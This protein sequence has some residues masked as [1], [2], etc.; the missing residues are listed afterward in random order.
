MPFARFSLL[1]N[2]VFLCVK[3]YV[4]ACVLPLSCTRKVVVDNKKFRF[5]G[6]NFSVGDHVCLSAPDLVRWC[7]AIY[8][9]L[10]TFPVVFAVVAGGR[11]S[12]FAVHVVV[13]VRDEL[14]K[15]VPYVSTSPEN[16]CVVTTT[17]SSLL[18][19][20]STTV[21]TSKTSTARRFLCSMT[22]R[23]VVVES[24]FCSC[25]CC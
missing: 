18:S 25:C 13:V 7:A 10:R 17:S 12:R 15:Y 8:V 14:C 1:R 2:D 11:C 21:V 9:P 20:R 23:Q 5:G 19:R 22:T 16:D 24:V 6:E 3:V 4:P